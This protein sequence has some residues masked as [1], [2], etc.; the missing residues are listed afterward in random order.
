MTFYE[1]YLRVNI[2]LLIFYFKFY[3]I[4]IVFFLYLLTYVYLF[5]VFKY[6]YT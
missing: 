5:C 1:C 4:L 3:N 2:K 6:F